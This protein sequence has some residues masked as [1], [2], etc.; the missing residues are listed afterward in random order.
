VT[1]VTMRDVSRAGYEFDRVELSG[2]PARLTVR[3]LLE[4]RVR[5]DVA[6]H[7]RAPSRVFRGLVQPADAIRHSDGHR[8]P[9]ARTLDAEP[10]VAAAHAAVTAG[11]LAVR[12]GGEVLQDLDAVIE[13]T[14][15]DEVVA[16]LRRPVVASGA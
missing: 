8:L 12:A 6:T 13:L 11:L 15:G 3:E 4:H 1:A 2:L 16:E 9:S 7:A 5:L 10:M 14:A